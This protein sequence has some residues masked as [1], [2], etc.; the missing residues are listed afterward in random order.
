MDIVCR[1]TEC[2]YNKDY[3]CHAKGILIDKKII[4]ATHEPIDEQ[5][6]DYSKTLPKKT[7]VYGKHRVVRD[8]NLLCK[9]DCLFNHNGYCEA[10]GITINSLDEKPYCITFLKH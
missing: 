4:C 8:L 10:N 7:P 2:K 5:K 9:A 6:P 1:K 3:V